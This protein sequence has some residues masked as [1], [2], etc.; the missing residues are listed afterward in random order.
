M[1]NTNNA[2]QQREERSGRRFYNTFIQWSE[3]KG[4]IPSPDLLRQWDENENSSCIKKLFGSHDDIY[5][6]G[7]KERYRRFF[8]SYS[9]LIV[10]RGSKKIKVC[11]FRK[12]AKETGR[13]IDFSSP[14]TS[15]AELNFARSKAHIVA[16]NAAAKL[17]MFN[18]P[19]AEVVRIFSEAIEEAYA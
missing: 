15:I 2:K 3:N 4:Y 9:M 11:R 16:L 8:T 13:F 7:L 19:K 14:S 6:E 5:E 12:G 10:T 1:T 18:E 17:R